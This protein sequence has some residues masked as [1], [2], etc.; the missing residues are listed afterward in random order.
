MN[1]DEELKDIISVWRE[2]VETKIIPVVK[3]FNTYYEGNIFSLDHNYD[4]NTNF[5]DKQKN[6]I[7][8]CKQPNVKNVLN[9]GFNS[10]NSTLLMLLSNPN[11]TITCV[12]IK[13]HVYV[14]SC[15]NIINNLFK[16]RITFLC[17]N[18]IDIL[19]NLDDKFDL[20]HIDGC[21]NTSVVKLDIE[22][23]IKLAN[24]NGILIMDDYDYEPIKKIWDF[25]T[26]LYKL[27][28]CN[29]KIQDNI[30]QSIKIKT[31]TVIQKNFLCYYTCFFG[32]NNNVSNVVPNV[33]SNNYDCYY[34]TNNTD[35][36]LDLLNTP[37]IPVLL[38]DIPVNE[39][40][41]ISSFQSKELK[42]CP[43]RF[44]QLTK[45][46]YTCYFDSK[47]NLYEDIILNKITNMDQKNKIIC[48]SKHHCI[49]GKVWD[50]YTEAINY[51]NRY[52][53][54]K[55]R[56]SNYINKNLSLDFKDTM[57]LLLH[58]NNFLR[59]NYQ[60]NRDKYL[61]KF[62]VNKKISNFFVFDLDNSI[63]IYSSK[64][65]DFLKMF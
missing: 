46:K 4:Y 6:I 11:I 58:H 61:E 1:L 41:N 29:F 40:Y 52:Y 32:S 57:D 34:F 48:I 56:Y 15:F 3:S 43:H 37:W 33:P 7:I 28:N 26:K 25:N 38:N 9:I 39:D 10:G 24:T 16:N 19:K 22:N 12:D 30:Y 13:S 44:S 21:N 49:Q 50:E 59:K 36:Y 42:A 2:I 5:L 8:S 45:Y 54:E 47:L 35:K 23:S 60:P 64:E 63:F 31:E 18:S 55:D 20:I 17:G 27:S 14:D 62:G 53:I 51:Q 65:K